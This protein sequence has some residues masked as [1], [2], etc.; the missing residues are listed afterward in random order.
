MRKGKHFV[1]CSESS[2]VNAL[3]LCTTFVFIYVSGDFY[4]V[5]INGILYIIELLRL[6]HFIAVALMVV[7][8]IS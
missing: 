5:L 1:N 7:N 8:M 3:C 2:N 6:K 4:C